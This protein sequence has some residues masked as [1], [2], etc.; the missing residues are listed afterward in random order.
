MHYPKY[1]VLCTETTKTIGDWI[2]NDILCWC[3]L[4]NHHRQQPCLHKKTLD[5][6]GKHYHIC[7][8]WILGYNP[9]VSGIMERTHFNICQ[10]LFKA[11]DSDQSK[12]H[13]VVTSVMWA[14]HVTVCQH[15][16]CSPYF[17]VT[18]T[19]PLLPLDIAEATYLLPPPNAPLSTTNLITTCTVA[20]QKWCT[21][22]MK[23]ASNVYSTC[24]KATICFEQ[25]H[26]STITDYDFKLGDLVL[27]QN[28]AIEKLLNHKMHTRYI[29]PL[30]IISRNRGGAYIIS[31]LNSSVFDHLIATFW[32]IP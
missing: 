7:H 31:E 25:E 13:S 18:R 27:I 19:H 28:T 17:A 9:H 29:S 26:A 10:A 6:L 30:I 24:I 12:W 4:W 11:C 5:Y 22:L 20:L 2:F 21:H 23:L 15:M 32:V 3:S 1:H 8:I 14:D 16:G